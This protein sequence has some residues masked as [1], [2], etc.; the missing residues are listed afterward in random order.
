M[1]EARRMELE[2]L[3]QK[4]IHAELS[5]RHRNKEGR[6]E[7]ARSLWMSKERCR[8]EVQSDGMADEDPGGLFWM[9]RDDMTSR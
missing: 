6:C 7:T 8:A 4:G 9:S 5:H 3:F 2:L 1:K